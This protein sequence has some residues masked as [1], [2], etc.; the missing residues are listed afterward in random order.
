MAQIDLSN[1]EKRE[2]DKYYVQEKINSSYSVFII[3]DEKYFQID[4]YGSS[5]RKLLGKAS[6]AIQFDKT[7]AK[8]LVEILKREYNL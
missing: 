7:V 2:K 4:T 8:V 1:F 3:N 6:Q 5:D